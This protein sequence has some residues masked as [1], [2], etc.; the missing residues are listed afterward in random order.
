MKKVIFQMSVSVDGYI[1][2]PHHE[3]D[4]HLVDDEF[5]AYAVEMLDAADVLIMGRRTYELM[6]GYWPTATDNDPVVT[7]RMNSTPKLVFS[8]TLKQVE[9]QNSHLATGSIAEEVPRLKQV[10]GD[11]VL[12]VGGSDLAAAF[13]EQGLMDELHIILT[14]VVLGGEKSRV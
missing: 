13:L 11:G 1:E 10:P 7:E 5:N 4:W 8:R 9:W 6:A 12:P 2:G 3:I 14:P